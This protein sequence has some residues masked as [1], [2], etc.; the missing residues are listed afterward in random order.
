MPTPTSGLRPAGSAQ[1]VG[2][3]G[4]AI[5]ARG[6]F[7]PRSR[8]GRPRDLGECPPLS[9]V[10]VDPRRAR[11]KAVRAATSITT[12]ASHN[13]STARSNNASENRQMS[14]VLHRLLRSIR[15]AVDLIRARP[16][17]IVPRV[18]FR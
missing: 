8:H 2:R 15:L 18:G 7:R 11:G 14:P 16:V 9:P 12:D 5:A 17:R 4:R 10:P 1:A 6:R 13:Q 3:G